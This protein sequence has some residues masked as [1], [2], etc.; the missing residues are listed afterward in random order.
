MW[1]VDGVQ[2]LIYSIYSNF[3]KGAIL[4]SDFTLKDCYIA[5][6]ENCFA[7]GT[8]LR[9]AFIDARSKALR[10]RPLEDR[11]KS[12]VEAH[13]SNVKYSGKDLFEW[14]NI[15]TGSCKMGRES[16]CRQH[17]ID[18][19]KDEFFVVDFISLTQN[20]YGGDVIRQLKKYYDK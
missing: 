6:E 8:T 5:K 19:D 14:H 12:F 10:K 4:E 7:H 17:Q 15:L 11:V 16:F 18:I 13:K 1:I 2:T 9:E 3:A 20:A